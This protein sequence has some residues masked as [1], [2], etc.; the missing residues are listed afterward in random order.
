M[1][2]SIPV[3]PPSLYSFL[4]SLTGNVGIEK[5]TCPVRLTRHLDQIVIDSPSQCIIR[6]CLAA[7]F[8][9]FVSDMGIPVKP[10]GIPN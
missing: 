5:G 8:A 9:G 2:N 6:L 4:S 7:A 3:C 1:G 10:I